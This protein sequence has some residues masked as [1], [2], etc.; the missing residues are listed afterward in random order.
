MVYLDPL[1]VSVWVDETMLNRLELNQPCRVIFRSDPDKELKGKVARIAP[2]TDRE[3]REVLVDVLLDELPKTWAV[4][5]R[6]E[7]FIEI[8][9]EGKTLALPQKTIV[10]QQSQP[11]VFII[12]NGKTNWVKINIGLQG[13]G[14]VQILQGLHVGQMVLIPGPQLPRNGRAVIILP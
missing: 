10:W 3:T 14:K 8:A 6:V 2:Q 9:R 1:W 12:E 4:G 5:Q 7:V 11:G 13:K